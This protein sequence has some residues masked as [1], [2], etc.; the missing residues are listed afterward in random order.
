[1]IKGGYT[2]A[3]F[4]CPYCNK[5]TYT[6]T[7]Y[8]N[9]ITAMVDKEGKDGKHSEYKDSG[10]SFNEFTTRQF[11]AD[12]PRLGKCECGKDKPYNDIKGKFAQYCG[13][14]EC[15]ERIRRRYED[16]VNEKYNTTNLAALPEH[17]RKMMGGW[18][19]NK[20]Y[21]ASNGKEYSVLSEVEVKILM[22]LDEVEKYNMDD[23]HAPAPFTI[24]YIDQ[25]H[26]TSNHFVDIYLEDLNVAISAKE[27]IMSPNKHS[28]V[29]Q[30]RKD[31]FLQFTAIRDNTDMHYF[32]IEG[33]EHVR[34][35]TRHLANIRKMKTNDR[36]IISPKIDVLAEF[37]GEKNPDIIHKETITHSVTLSPVGFNGTPTG[38]NICLLA[39]DQSSL[40]YTDRNTVYVLNNEKK[41]L[42]NKMIKESRKFG[43]TSAIVPLD[44]AYSI[45]ELNLSDDYEMAEDGHLFKEMVNRTLEVLT[46]PNLVIFK[47]GSI[48]IESDPLLFRESKRNDIYGDYDSYET[49]LE[50]LTKV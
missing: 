12:N 1:M 45:D 43:Y 42:F 32:Q 6:I 38:E 16:N 34:D 35:I 2:M 27:S 30:K 9:H 37:M 33:E 22:Y 39:S 10:L 47:E 5:A 28:A 49:L 15:A 23:V 11:Y 48:N 7:E 14:P 4:R 50:I 41:A 18:K 31:N 44:R 3:V 26:K 19:R 13:A 29:M 25:H 36:Y 8:R 24:E 46:R 40:Y 17:Q 20:H 21:T